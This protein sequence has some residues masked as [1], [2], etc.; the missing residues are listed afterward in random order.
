[1]ALEA[2][3][4][5]ARG[6]EISKLPKGRAFVDVT[7]ELLLQFLKVSKDGEARDHG[8]VVVIRDAI[9]DDAKVLR[10]GTTDNGYV[11]LVF[12][13]GA[14]APQWE[15]EQLRRFTPTYANLYWPRPLARLLKSATSFLVRQAETL[16]WPGREWRQK[17]G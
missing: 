8:A 4:A 17:D 13:T 16:P 11:R 12:E 14:I 9:P 1:M 7:P 2:T 5:N 10:C 15:N 3:L 6:D